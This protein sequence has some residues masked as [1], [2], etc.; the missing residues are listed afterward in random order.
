MANHEDDAGVYGRSLRS[1]LLYHVRP[2]KPRHPGRTPDRRPGRCVR[3][4][5]WGE[6]RSLESVQ[7]RWRSFCMA[8]RQNGFEKNGGHLHH[9][10]G[11]KGWILSHVRHQRLQMKQGIS[12]TRSHRALI[13]PSHSAS[14]SVPFLLLSGRW[15]PQDGPVISAPV[16]SEAFRFK[17]SSTRSFRAPLAQRRGILDAGFAQGV[18]IGIG[19]ASQ[20]RRAVFFF[21]RNSTSA[22]GIVLHGSVSRFWWK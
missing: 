16:K 12:G 22:A 10:S 4:P 8:L 14:E 9:L 15:T 18:I 20:R 3:I 19:R 6:M 5:M 7:T 21:S 2:G 1:G 11:N 17:K 13:F